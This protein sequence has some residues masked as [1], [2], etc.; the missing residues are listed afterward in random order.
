MIIRIL[1][2][3][4]GARRAEGLAV[5]IDVFRAFTTACHLFAAGAERILAVAEIERAWELKRQDPRR[6]LLGERDCVPLPGFDFGN[7]P[8]LI[9]GN[10]L[11][12]REIIQTTS[13][14]TRGLL[15]AARAGASPIVTGA[16][17]NAPATA[18]AIL[19][20]Q[21]ETVSLVALGTS[22]QAPS[23]E[24]EALAD[25]MA[26]LLRGEAMEQTTPQ[27]LARR[28]R[29][30]ESARKFFDPAQPWAPEEDFER[31]LDIGRFDFAIFGRLQEPGLVV[32]LRQNL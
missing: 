11:R 22:G 13:A 21:P 14:G 19:A 16:F 27:S 12:G 30:V 20:R 9:D 24:D 3:I 23:E 10:D 31:C 28:L 15:A 2:Q 8:H 17:A 1:H 32:L 26:G 6:V 29:G 7:S 5:V 18:R 4:E 25:Y